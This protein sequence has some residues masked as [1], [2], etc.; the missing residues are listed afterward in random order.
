MRKLLHNIHHS[1]S[2]FD[3][4]AAAGFGLI[5]ALIA[6]GIIGILAGLMSQSF[7]NNIQFTKKIIARGEVEDLRRFVRLQLSCKNTLL[8]A[9]VTCPSPIPAVL[10]DSQDN[11]FVASA[12]KTIG[13]YVV[14]AECASAG[15]AKI[16]KI[17]Y[18][19]SGPSPTY[20]DL[21]SGSVGC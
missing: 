21:F 15:G 14:K 5:E 2:P 1:R 3:K 16:I 18:S 20:V 12:G 10:K 13:K 6:V 19:K 9:P 7:S 4:K 8:N 17:S 11:V